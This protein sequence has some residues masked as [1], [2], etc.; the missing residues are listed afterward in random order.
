MI[1]IKVANLTGIKD[2]ISDINKRDISEMIVRFFKNLSLEE[3]DYAFKME[4]YG[5]LEPKSEHYQLFNAEYV[6][7]ILNKYKKFRHKVR[8]QLDLPIA[9]IEKPKELSE[10]DKEFIVINGVLNCFENFKQTKSIEIGSLY[11]YDYLFE[12]GALPFHSK[13][14][15]SKIKR[16]A[17]REIY[18]SRN[19]FSSIKDKRL[20]KNILISIQN[21]ENPVRTKCQEL[22]LIEFFSRV[23]NTNQSFTDLL[24]KLRTQKLNPNNEQTK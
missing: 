22:I 16:K 7:E 3:I 5:M 15:K 12:L 2:P 18:K 17:I 20:V 14:F 23:I 10:E 1:F 11:V 4:R 13:R 21:N 8:V 9:K 6:S 19:N 24:S